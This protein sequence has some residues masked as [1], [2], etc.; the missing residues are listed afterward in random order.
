MWPTARAAGVAV[1]RGGRRDAD[2]Q[3]AGRH[4]HG[5]RFFG[6][7]AH[8]GGGRAGRRG[9]ISATAARNR[10]L[11]R[12]SRAGL[13]PYRREWWHYESR[14]RCPRCANASACSIFELR[15]RMFAEKVVILPIQN[16]NSRIWIPNSYYNTL[17]RRKEEFEPLG[18]G[19]RG[20]VCLRSHGLRR[21]APGPRP[22]RRDLRPAVPLPQSRRL[23]GA[24][25]AQRHGR[26]PS[27][28]R[29]RRG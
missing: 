18:S 21:P 13:V 16:V 19:P 12:S 14:C 23:Q 25:R 17:T 10:E 8:T 9:K 28:A 1:R 7:E 22:A 6:E 15:A 27:G 24:L 2:A 3:G 20:H 11:L 4:G 29:R 5:G 26:G